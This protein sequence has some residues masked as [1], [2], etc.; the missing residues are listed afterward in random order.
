MWKF[1][2]TPMAFVSPLRGFEPYFFTIS[3]NGA[4]ANAAFI[5]SK[6]IWRRISYGTMMYW[7]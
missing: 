6:A 4:T 1:V 2:E 3:T 5:R 7:P